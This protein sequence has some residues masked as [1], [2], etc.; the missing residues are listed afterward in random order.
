M[1]KAV[2]L[3]MGHSKPPA[4]DQPIANP[5]SQVSVQPPA[6]AYSTNDSQEVNALIEGTAARIEHRAT[7]ISTFAGLKGTEVPVSDLSEYL[8]THSPGEEVTLDLL[9]DALE[10]TGILPKISHNAQ[11]RPETWPALTMMRGG[12]CVLVLSQNGDTLSIFDTTCPDNRAEV[13]VSEFA[14]VFSGTTLTGR[15]SLKQMAAR[16]TPKLANDHW[17]WGEFPK[18]RRQVGEIMLGSLVSN[19]L[20]VSVALFSLQVYDR[21]IPHQS[22]ATLWVLAMGA[23]LAIGLEAMLKLARARLTDA[24]GRQIE[25]SVQRNLMQRLIGMRSDK[26][27]LPPSGL[28]AAMRDFGSVREFFTSSTIATLADVP[29]VAVFL[30]LVASIAG[31]IV[32]VIVFGGI[33]ML[34]PAYFMQ[35][36]MIALTRQTQGANAK[37]GRLLHEVVSELDTLKTQRGEERMLRI[38]DELNALSSQSS[39]EQRRLSSALTYWSQGIQ[40]VTYVA[41]VVLGTFMVFAGEFTVGTIIATGIL[42]SRTLAPLTQFAGTMARWTN[43]KAA[44]EALDAIAL[45]PQ[46]KEANRS[47]LRRQTLQGRFDL[48]EVEYRY[49]EDG[50]P[51]LDVAGIAITPGQRIAVLGANGSGKSTLL[52]V[53]SGLYSPDRGRIM[54][55]GTDMAQIDPRDLRRNIGYLSQEVRLFTGSLRDNL[56][57]NQLERNDERLLHALDFAGLGAYVRGHHKGLDLQISDGGEGLSIGQ[58]QS[59]GWARLWLQDPSVVLLDEPTAALDQ[60]LERTLVSRLETWLQGRTAV[61]A[62]HRM[63]ILSLTNRTLILQA[64]RMVVDG[65]RDQVLAH[66]AAGEGK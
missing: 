39:T 34:L 61:I 30:L 10:T 50:S 37:A 45:A 51:T 28:F 24:A 58:R 56:N 19:L 53:L 6:P 9:A 2:T 15:A 8:W 40:Q 48:R 60:T 20:A 41:A 35:K 63:P 12:Q 47:Y 16:H 11:V 49:E 4:S 7:L 32:W 36:R 3:T 52:K 62:T 42:T 57:L 66:L 33:L 65:P 31:P 13:P 21:V 18:Y 38:W 5:Q 29:F 55:D 17:F 43:V 27:P 54:I 26:K 46:E 14:P 44:L 1:T 64:G 22:Q 23:L 25:L 59:I